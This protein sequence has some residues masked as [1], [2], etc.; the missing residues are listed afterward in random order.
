LWCVVVE[1]DRA[2]GDDAG[3]FACDA[4]AVVVVCFVGCCE[5]VDVAVDCREGPWGRKAAMKEERKKGRWEEG[6]AMAVV[7]V[8]MG[9]A[10][11]VVQRQFGRL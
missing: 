10:R 9:V 7:C 5:G 1:Y 3:V 11:L 6:M 4:A 2:A 8:G